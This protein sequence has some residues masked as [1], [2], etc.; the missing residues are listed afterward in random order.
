M[1]RSI[2]S[3]D[4]PVQEVTDQVKLSSKDFRKEPIQLIKAFREKSWSA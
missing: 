3:S 2:S 4:L 1:E